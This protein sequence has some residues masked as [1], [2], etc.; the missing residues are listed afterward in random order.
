[1][2]RRALLGGTLGDYAPPS[3]LCGRWWRF[4]PETVGCGYADV[5]LT[6]LI[7]FFSACRDGKAGVP[8]MA[9]IG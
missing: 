8:I 7:A 5:T 9:A 2:L 4:S 6:R 1:M 3:R